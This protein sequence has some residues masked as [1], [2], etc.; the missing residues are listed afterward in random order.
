VKEY[1]RNGGR[2]YEDNKVIREKEERYDF[3][4]HP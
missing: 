4:C 3:S 1:R 2:K